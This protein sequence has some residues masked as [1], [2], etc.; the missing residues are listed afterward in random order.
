V[1]ARRTPFWQA[2]FA[3]EAVRRIW[4]PAM[5]IGAAG[6]CF[7]DGTGNGDPHLEEKGTP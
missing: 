6:P 1:V 4:R 3:L 5:G 7:D 2:F